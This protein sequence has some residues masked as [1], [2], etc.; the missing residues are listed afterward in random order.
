MFHLHQQT[1]LAISTINPG[2]T[3]CWFVLEYDEAIMNYIESARMMNEKPVI[4]QDDIVYKV[5]L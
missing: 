1:S 5:D 4:Y 3:E 2:A